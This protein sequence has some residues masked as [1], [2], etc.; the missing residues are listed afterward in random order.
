MA[1]LL[2]MKSAD[3][4]S[5]VDKSCNGVA[6]SEHRKD[7]SVIAEKAV[8]SAEK[9]LEIEASSSEDVFHAG[10]DLVALGQNGCCQLWLYKCVRDGC[11]AAFELLA[12]LR[13]HFICNH[14][15]T[16]I[17]VYVCI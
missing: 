14:Q 7:I 1:Q 16:G 11:S 15:T 2:A 13:A 10:D 12:D 9:S 4:S 17:H 8:N 5:I 3:E 6:D